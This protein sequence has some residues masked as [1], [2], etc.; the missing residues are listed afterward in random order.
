MPKEVWT[1]EKV[2]YILQLMQEPLSLDEKI[3]NGE[4]DMDTSRGDLIPD[5]RPSPEDIVFEND[6]R[7]FLE[8]MI[9]ERLSPREAMVIKMRYGFKTGSPMTLEEIGEYFGLTRE[10]IRQVEQKAIR[11]LKW[12]ITVKN[13]LRDGDI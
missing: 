13:E 2:S 4:N 9:D 10:R 7:A 6:K 5:D 8:R 3:G 12:Y 11:K 1:A